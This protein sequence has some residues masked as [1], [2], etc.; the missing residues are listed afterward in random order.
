VDEQRDKTSWFER[1]REGLTKTRDQWV[2]RVDEVLLGKK[3]LDPETREE[4]E[5]LFLAADLGVRLTERLLRSVEENMSRSDLADPLGVRRGLQQ[6]VLRV[7]EAVPQGLRFHGDQ[8]VVWLI[9]G[10]NGVGKT[11]TIG[12]L[13]ARFR[14]E[15]RSVLAVAGDTFRAAAIEQLQVWGERAGVPVLASQPGADPAAL[16]HDAMAAAKA[17]GIDLVLI[18]T[19]GRLH[20]KIHLMEE[21]KKVRRVLGRAHPGAPHETLLV[22]DA[23][24]GQNALQQARLFH[25]AVGVSGLVLTKLDGTAKGGVV[26]GITQELGLPVKLLGVGEGIDDLQEFDPRAFV[27]ALFDLTS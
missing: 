4:L 14:Q 17:R 19:A 21:L 22:L 9:V 26:V 2:D 3:T 20:T 5:A 23:T 12:K 18:D 13:A 8:P 7:L 16:A 27:E 10:V 24:T 1:L 6:E 25:E 15:G 11:T